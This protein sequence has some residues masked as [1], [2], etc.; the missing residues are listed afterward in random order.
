MQALKLKNA[1]EVNGKATPSYSALD[2][3]AFQ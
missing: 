1:R 2:L 3:P